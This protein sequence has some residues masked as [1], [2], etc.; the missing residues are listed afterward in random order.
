MIYSVA[1]ICIL[2]IYIVILQKKLYKT[3]KNFKELLLENDTQATLIQQQQK[4]IYF[5]T[6]LDFMI[7]YA[8][9]ATFNIL[10]FTPDELIGEHVLGTVFENNDANLKALLSDFSKVSKKQATINTEQILIKKDGTK[11]LMQCRG[12]PILNSILRCEGMSFMCKDFSENLR[13]E[14]EIKSYANRDMLVTEILNEEVFLKRLE[15][16]FR[17]NKRYNNE[18]SLVVIELLD[19]Y[20]FINKGIDFETGDKLLKAAAEICVTTAGNDKSIGRFDKTK[21]GIILSKT[22]REDAVE[23]SKKLYDLIVAKIRTLGVDNYNAEMIIISYTNR[24]NTND[25]D[26]LMLERVRRHIRNAMR[27]H[28]YG[29]ISS[30]IKEIEN[31][32]E[33]LN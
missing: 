24:K 10:G 28:K 1:V 4:D 15:H 27:N 19:I 7:T 11:L 26:D 17:V 12:R 18:F 23:L 32:K 13:M 6:D 22:S 29:I 16:D 25:T 21:F 31:R 3:K 14:Q 5:K 33:I 2:T 9:E 20:E 30:N 8:N